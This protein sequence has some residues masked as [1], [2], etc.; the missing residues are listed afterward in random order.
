MTNLLKLSLQNTRKIPLLNFTL[1]SKVLQS[2]RLGNM[3][4]QQS[5]FVQNL[6][7]LG[8]FKRQGDV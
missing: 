1:P 6:T 2:K 7:V 3:Y 4:A 8:K 5:L